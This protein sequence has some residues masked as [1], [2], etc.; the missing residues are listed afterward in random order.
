MN[1]TRSFLVLLV[2]LYLSACGAAQRVQPNVLDQLQ[3]S[4][5]NY[6]ESQANER[7]E[8]EAA[9][10]AQQKADQAAQARLKAAQQYAADLGNAAI[11]R[12]AEAASYRDKMCKIDPTR[13]ERSVPHKAQESFVD[14]KVTVFGEGGFAK[15]SGSVYPDGWRVVFGSAKFSLMVDGLEKASLSD[16]NAAGKCYR[17]RVGEFVPIACPQ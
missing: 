15:L 14:G 17:V 1:A 5:A 16:S 11:V 13:C 7:R 6:G 9:L 4:E 2:A 3:L 8:K 12:E 10:A